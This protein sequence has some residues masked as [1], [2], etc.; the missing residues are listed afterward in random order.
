MK[1]R[2][3]TMALFVLLIPVGLFGLF[4]SQSGSRWLLTQGM[5]WLPGKLTITSIQGRLLDHLELSELHYQSDA[6]NLTLNKLVL[7]WQPAQLLSGRLTIDHLTLDGLKIQFDNTNNTETPGTLDINKGLRLP[8]EITIAH[9]LL[10]DLEFSRGKQVQALQRLQ[11][12]LSTQGDKLRLNN[13]ELTAQPLNAKAQGTVRLSKGFPLNLNADW[14]LNAEANGLWQGT[15]TL[16][17]DLKQLVFTSQLA[18]PFKLTL[19]GQARDVL[20]D[21][22]FDMHG[23][24]QALQWPF[25]GKTVQLKSEQG[26]FDVIGLLSDYK[27]SVQSQLTQSDL[28][29]TTLLLDGHGSTHK[30]SINQL[31]LVSTLGQLQLTGHVSWHN[32]PEFDLTLTGNDFNPALLLPELAGNLTINSHI[33]GNFG[34]PLILSA[35]INQLS[36]KLRGFPVGGTGK[37]SLSGEQL[38]VDAFKLISGRNT[39]AANGILDEKQSSLD[40]SIKAPSLA[41]LWPDL[42][43]NLQALGHVQGNW[44]NPTLTLQANGKKL[45]YTDHRLG[46]LA[47]DVSYNADRKKNSTAAISVKDLHSGKL[48]INQ[49]QVKGQGL[50]EQHQIQAD[51]RSNEGNVTLV[52]NGQ[53]QD[54]KWLGNISKLNLSRPDTGLWQLKNLTQVAVKKDAAGFFVDLKETCLRQASASLCSQVN[55]ASGDFQLNLQAVSLPSRLLNPYLPE[56]TKIASTLNGELLLQQKQ[57]LLTGNYQA[58]MSPP[59]L[60]LT[61][62]GKSIEITLGGSNVSGIIKGD[63][64]LADFN[65]ALVKQDFIRGQ[66]QLDRGNGKAITGHVSAAVNEFSW[67]QTFVPQL[68]ELKGHLA[69]NVAIT[70]TLDKPFIS[71]EIN[72]TQGRVD[73]GELGLG[74]R[75]ITL[76]ANSDNDKLIQLRGSALPSTL[77]GAQL[78]EYLQLQGIWQINAD[79]HQDNGI[80]T[81][82]YRLDIPAGSINLLQPSKKPLGATYLRGHVD[83]NQQTLSIASYLVGKDVVQAQLQ[84]NDGKSKALSGRIN[85]SITEFGLFNPLVPQ[86]SNLE[87]RLLA[88]LD[89]TGTTIHPVATGTI[90]VSDASA[91]VSD[92]GI[93]LTDV[94]VQ[95]LATGDHTE[96]IKLNGSAKSGNGAIH[97]EGGFGL[98]GSSEQ[99]LEAHIT[100]ADFEIAKLPEA[101]IAVSPDLTFALREGKGRITGRIK[102]PNAFLQIEE[103][104]ENAVTVSKDEIIVGAEPPLK[105]SAVVGVNANIDVELGKEVSFSGKGLKTQLAGKIKVIKADEKMTMHGNVAMEKG[106]YKSYGQDLTI[107]KGNFVFNGPVDNPLLDVEA[108]RISKDK[109][110][111]AILAVSGNLNSPKTQVSSQPAL[112]ESEALAYL[113]TGRS[114]N[115]ASK[116]ESDMLAGA[117]LSYGAGKATWL[118][119]KLGIDEFE[120]EEGE[121][122]QDSL[123]SVGQYL[124]PDFYVGTKV[125]LFN[126]QASLILKYLVT[127]SINVETQTG[128]SKRVKLNYE[129]DTD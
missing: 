48:Q 105:S 38:K 95:A 107:R 12:S 91:D 82:Q 54:K 44:R 52:L 128:S 83:G 120:L 76:H 31:K 29:K 69:G 81:G 78:A 25:T 19:N 97:F 22:S 26:S 43:G 60:T 127:D 115:Q 1:K 87:G 17:G 14:R 58:A 45:G 51:M 88:D 108:I 116:S 21:P 68:S 125:G 94:K 65:L 34:K 59:Q 126:K 75:D 109:K 57:G 121:T 67:I 42:T 85:A 37:L 119:D 122:L 46:L 39:I 32:A 9:L 41:Q 36:G 89:V 104:P 102:V 66:L 118:T 72:L 80:K 124:T 117:A 96:R 86:L 33:Q 103:L 56:S 99:A 114:L 93:R 35:E 15:T 18:S 123:V 24:W 6:E 79:L 7:D 47:I 2:L 11:L 63:K 23:D 71:G 111:T 90:K 106:R 74:F 53:H 50:L 62:A 101:Q 61:T 8:V 70:G 5:H 10:T 3:V 16:S 84:L 113:V 40:L 13:L 49:L 110:V 4:S 73:L 92:L 77:K 129:Y 20:I 30:L 100:G 28:P 55:Y 98:P 112:P 27:I 64:L